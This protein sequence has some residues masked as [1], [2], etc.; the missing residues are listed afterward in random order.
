MATRVRGDATFAPSRHAQQERTDYTDPQ[1]L[2]FNNLLLLG[3]NAAAMEKKQG[4]L[5]GPAMFSNAGATRQCDCV[6]HFLL[7]KIFPAD[8]AAEFKSVW[9]IMDRVQQRDFKKIACG[10]LAKL[11]KFEAIPS[12][13]QIRP[14]TLD[15]PIGDRFCSLLWAVSNH[16]LAVEFKRRYPTQYANTPRLSTAHEL[17]RIIIPVAA[18]HEQ[19]LR[20]KFLKSA[21]HLANLDSQWT[22]VGEAL[23]S[24]YRDLRSQ[25]A[26]LQEQAHVA[27]L[28][29]LTSAEHDDA[30][31]S[32]LAHVREWHQRFSADY[33]G[34]ESARALVLDILNQRAA[35]SSLDATKIQAALGDGNDASGPVDLSLVLDKWST[36]LEQLCREL[37]GQNGRPSA[38]AGVAAQA[39][40]LG[41]VVEKRNEVLGAVVKLRQEAADALT[42]AT[43]S[44]RR[45]IVNLGTHAATFPPSPSLRLAPSPPPSGD[46]FSATSPAHVAGNHTAS[47]PSTL[48]RA[49]DRLWPLESGCVAAA[50]ALTPAGMQRLAD[51]VRK[52][53]K[54]E[55]SVSVA[56]VS[57]DD[58]FDLNAEVAQPQFSASDDM[59]RIDRSG[60]TPKDTATFIGSVSAFIGSVFTPPESAV[61][62]AT[63]AAFLGS[64]PDELAHSA[65]SPYAHIAKGES[66]F[67]TTPEHLKKLESLQRGDKG[68]SSAS[69]ITSPVFPSSLRKNASPPPPPPKAHAHQDRPAT[70]F[71]AV[72]T[73]PSKRTVAAAPSKGTG[74][75][76]SSKQ[77]LLSAAA[78]KNAA[79]LRERAPAAVSKESESSQDD[80]L[81]KELAA[82]RRLALQRMSKNAIAD[83]IADGIVGTGEIFNKNPFEIRKELPRTPE[84]PPA[85]ATFTAVQNSPFVSVSL[86][87]A[88]AVNQ[89]SAEVSPAAFD[90]G[91]STGS[92][93][94]ESDTFVPAQHSP[95]TSTHPQPSPAHRS[96]AAAY[97]AALLNP[98]PPRVTA[99]AIDMA[100]PLL[101]EFIPSYASSSTPVMAKFVP[102]S[103]VAHPPSPSRYAGDPF[104]SSPSAHFNMPHVGPEQS[105]Q[106]SQSGW[107]SCRGTPDAVAGPEAE[108][109]DVPH[110]ASSA[111]S[112]LKRR[113][114]SQSDTSN[115][116]SPDLAAATSTPWK[117]GT[118]RAVCIARTHSSH[119]CAASS[120]PAAVGMDIGNVSFDDDSGELAPALRQ[121][122]SSLSK[123]SPARMAFQHDHS[124]PER[125]VEYQ[126]VGSAKAKV[127]DSESPSNLPR[128]GSKISIQAGA[129]TPS[130]SAIK[131]KARPFAITSK[132]SP[133]AGFKSNSAAWGVTVNSNSDADS[134]PSTTTSTWTTSS[135]PSVSASDNDADSESA[136]D[137]QTSA[138]LRLNA[139]K[140]KVASVLRD[141]DRHTG[142]AFQ[143]P[144]DA[145][146]T[147]ENT[148]EGSSNDVASPSERWGTLV[149][150]ATAKSPVSKFNASW[151]VPSPTRRRTSV[152]PSVL[153]HGVQPSPFNNPALFAS[154]P[155]D[156][157]MET[158]SRI[159]E[160]VTVN[161]GYYNPANDVSMRTAKD[162]PFVSQ[163]PTDMDISADREPVAS[164]QLAQFAGVHHVDQYIQFARADSSSSAASSVTHDDDVHSAPSG[165]FVAP[166]AASAPRM[167]VLKELLSFR[168]KASPSSHSSP[169]LS[170]IV[171]N[172]SM[173]SSVLHEAAIK[174]SNFA[175]SQDATSSKAVAAPNFQDELR[176][177]LSTVK[178]ST[179]VSGLLTQ[180]PL[181]ANAVSKPESPYV[182]KSVVEL[183]AQLLKS[184]GCRRGRRPRS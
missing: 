29:P 66:T 99:I 125:H 20:N 154:S 182:Q 113:D 114:S 142:P 33:T 15:T 78:A 121:T 56:G 138:Q 107:G 58:R 168:K 73:A 119:S 160:D 124:V 156:S 149:D 75:V 131:K 62:R 172:G 158:S 165:G 43:R 70:G 63:P 155:H 94:A 97:Y 163:S 59:P 90:S 104:P 159:D 175:P 183:R 110:S 40:A 106:S 34:E 47:T 2:M 141:S 48:R 169:Q 39:Q 83:E 84:A 101:K 67:I 71:Q 87:S 153:H 112:W 144:N 98:T 127:T 38:I 28:D 91:A 108:P 103:P 24:T 161:M 64:M 68:L 92:E 5:F 133:P 26:S 57:Q 150:A 120:I 36:S 13:P 137:P 44:L 88:A 115:L 53:A 61:P 100:S 145:T 85:T 151:C 52:A 111:S 157:S 22:Q 177:R 164:A 35:S 102:S 123:A 134:V 79:S 86:S 50:G 65:S 180:Q 181:P 10:M 135:V 140:S 147:S 46:M 93:D 173:A 4:V 17:A 117:A 146:L 143:L 116:P 1:V 32:E 170:R 184:Q 42:D 96:A 109:S 152:T 72:V 162:S 179:S 25:F 95:L 174:A 81:A 45:K 60:G 178:A 122:T 132:A 105:L 16:A 139:F 11:Q 19:L 30:E 6:V 77:R 82:K 118:S 55:A 12:Q 69:L 148:D 41:D 21:E 76:M 49:P 31:P 171:S 74:F 126:V 27:G 130:L 54:R 7:S 176:K 166:S 9:P 51:S 18:Q 23:G 128:T 136:P 167:E 8:A 37:G 89:L 3:F 129:A 14:T 80:Q